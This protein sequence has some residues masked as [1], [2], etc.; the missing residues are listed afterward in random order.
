MIRTEI[1]RAFH[2]RGSMGAVRVHVRERTRVLD[3]EDRV[4]AQA[5]AVA[6][7][8]GTWLSHLGAGFRHF[9]HVSKAGAYKRWKSSRAAIASAGEK[10]P[11]RSRN[12]RALNVSMSWSD[13]P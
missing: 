8:I 10:N 2:P 1:V 11:R 4:G 5:V 9:F 13:K 12:P 3:E 6:C 7:R